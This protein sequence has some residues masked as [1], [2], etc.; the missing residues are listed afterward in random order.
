[1][2]KGFMM[3]F[4][5]KLV[6]VKFVMKSIGVEWKCFS[7]FLYMVMYNILFLVIVI[8]DMIIRE[9]LEIREKVVLILF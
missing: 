1:M 2:Y 6:M 4:V 8:N 5:K 9:M 3:E 7:G